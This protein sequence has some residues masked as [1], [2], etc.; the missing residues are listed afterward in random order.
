MAVNLRTEDSRVCLS[1]AAQWSVLGLVSAVQVCP[2]AGK[3]PFT[4]YQVVTESD[5]IS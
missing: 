1:G 2:M 3:G 4:N 5:W